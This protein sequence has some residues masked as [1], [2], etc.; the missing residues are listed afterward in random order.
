[1]LIESLTHQ[2]FDNG[3]PAD[4]QVLSCLVQFLLHAGGDVHID[5]LNRLDHA[6][7]SGEEMGD[8][9][10]PIGQPRNCIGGLANKGGR[11][12]PAP[13][14]TNS[15]FRIRSEAL[16]F[17]RIETEAHGLRPKRDE[18]SP[19]QIPRT[20]TMVPRIHARSSRSFKDVESFVLH[21]RSPFALPP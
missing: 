20:L 15:A 5:A 9:F 6:A 19:T 11:T 4:V 21:T 13:F 17:S 8:V 14:R 2:R 12:T 1:M 10:S 18:S 3:L 7:F 16:A